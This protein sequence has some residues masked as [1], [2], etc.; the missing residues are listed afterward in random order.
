[1]LGRPQWRRAAPI[2]PRD[3]EEQIYAALIQPGDICFDI[4]A[5]EGAVAL[6]LARLAGPNGAVYSFEPVLRTYRQLCG[7]AQWDQHARAPIITLPFGLSDAPGQHRISI[8]NGSSGLG[9]LARPAAWS[10]MQLHYIETHLCDFTTID[11]LMERSYPQ[12]DFANIDVEGAELLVL[13]GADRTFA[14][15]PALCF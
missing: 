4:G 6:L 14:A 12:P 11:L 3:F 9:S 7:A 1:L 8:P 10:T 2:K 15:G 5:N 13:R